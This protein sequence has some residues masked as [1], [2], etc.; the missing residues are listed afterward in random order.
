[1]FWTG[2]PLGV[3][4]P[5][6]QIVASVKSLGVTCGQLGLDGKADLSSANAARWKKA[7]AD[8]GIT[9]VTCFPGF[10]GE[11]YA[12]I[13]ICAGTV[14]FVPKQP[15]AEREKR[16]FEAS[17]FARELGVPGL[18]SHVGCLPHDR[19]DPEYIAV[20]DLVRRLCDHCAA[21]GQTFA[22]ETGQEPAQNLLNFLADV[23]RENLKINFD[24]ANLILYGEGDPIEALEMVKD[25][26]VTVHAKDG[27][28]PKVKGEWGAE[29]PLGK[30]DV[31]MERF[32][33]KLKEVGYTGPLTIEREILGDEQRKDILEAIAL[34]ERLRA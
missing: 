32:V 24:P 7:L 10:E 18:A 8:A 14:G 20:R 34:L 25:H 17:D 19:S 33:D 31:G 22:L 4:A 6:E 21:H 1:M 23:D 16:A 12:S 27:S 15:R 2:G 11:S 28:W 3:E 30:G 26:L 5:P 13:P 29:T 9:V